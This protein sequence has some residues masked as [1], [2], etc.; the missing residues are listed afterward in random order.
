M[1]LMRQMALAGRAAAR[2]L[3]VATAEAKDRALVRMAELLKE[4]AGELK[5]ANALDVERARGLS[6]AMVDRLRLDDAR[7]AKMAEGVAQVSRL[8]DPVGQALRETTRP[9]G[10]R[11]VKRRVPIGVIAI[12]YESRP[13]VTADA[14]SLC[15]KSGNACI[16][17]GGKEAIESN[18]AIGRV[19]SD[20]LNESGLPGDAIQVVATADRSVVGELLTLDTLIDLV[21][22]R[23]G[24]GL[25]RRVVEE[26]TIP[27]IKHYE[28]ICHVYVDAAADFAMAE[29]IVLNAKTQ[30]PGV[31]N[32]METLLVHAGIAAAFLPRVVAA[33][34]ERGVAIRGCERS[35]AI[36]AGLEP[37]SETDY[38]TEW[39]DL[40]MSLRVVDDVRAAVEHI[41]AYGSRHSDAIVTADPAAAAY[42]LDN[43]DSACVFHN[44]TTRLSDGFEFGMGAEIGISTDKLHA[45]GP[46]GL[47]E[48]TS[49]KYVI[50]GDGQTRT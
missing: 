50:L 30:R 33:L 24:K 40:A 45:R 48:L 12:I 36:V 15:L 7:I 37:A 25:I 31:C 11:I 22:P 6:A 28:G 27:V 20:A 49:Y 44:V 41:E 35:R 8:P 9:N 13:N 5:D 21:I 2:A 18:R 32:A 17:R 26:S 19:L 46:M 39:L 34:R 29:S 10:M 4:R 23:G 42:F 16:L 3:A 1:G 14:A 43:V 47:E 38:R